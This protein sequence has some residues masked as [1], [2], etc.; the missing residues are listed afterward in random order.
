MDL[1]D[2]ILNNIAPIMDEWVRFARRIQPD[3]GRMSMTDLRDHAEAMLRVI[4]ADLAEPQSVRE[5][6]VKSQGNAPRPAATSAAEHHASARLHSGFSIEL[7]VAEFRALRASV[8][9]LWLAQEKGE[10][11][12]KRIT[13]TIRFNEAIDQAIE[14]S[15]AHFSAAVNSAQDVFIGILGHDLRSPLQAIS[16]GAQVL[17]LE[18]KHSELIQL[19]SRMYRSV[20]RMQGL[21]DNLLDFTR[22]R[23]GGGIEIERRTCDLGELVEQVVGEFRMSHPGRDLS[24]ACSG[25]C[26]GEWDSLRLGQVYQNLISN[27][28]QYG[29]PNQPVEIRTEGHEDHVIASIRN[30]GSSIPQ[31]HQDRLF[32]LYHRV[33]QAAESDRPRSNLGLGLYIAKEII[34][35]HQGSIQVES[36]AREG[37]TFTMKLPKRSS[38]R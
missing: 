16:S 1:D 38:D 14:E 34:E 18:E 31:E 15:V 29:D 17:M 7:L 9:R 25:D 30:Q 26:R 19:G 23:I 37:T 6:V 13:D 5:G 36:N 20:G 24:D 11:S 35:A 22:S 3:S 32:V 4:A 12:E 28:L 27:A 2:Y 33:A 21:L 8:L 10:I